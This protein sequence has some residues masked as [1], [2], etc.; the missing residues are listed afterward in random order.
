MKKHCYLKNNGKNILIRTWCFTKCNLT[1]IIVDGALTAAT[2]PM[3]E[4]AI[5]MAY[6]YAIARVNILYIKKSSNSPFILVTSDIIL[7]L[8]SGLPT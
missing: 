5:L 7:L 3:D 2:G 1:V 8:E 6:P 4:Q